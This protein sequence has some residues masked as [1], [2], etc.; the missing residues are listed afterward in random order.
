[1]ARRFFVPTD[2][3]ARLR[4]L[5]IVQAWFHLE[6]SR[7]FGRMLFLYVGLGIVVGL[8]A[9]VFHWAVA[10]AEF[11]FLD[12]MAGYRPATPGGEHLLIKP[13]STPFNPWLLAVMPAL[14]ATL[15]A[16]L[17]RTFAPEAW[18]AGTPAVIQGYHSGGIVRRRVTWVKTI[19]SAL[20]IGT[21]GSAGREGPIAQVGSALG[22]VVA[23]LLKLAP[24]ERRTLVAA[25]AAAGIGALFHAPVAS[26]LFIAEILYRRMELEHEVIVPGLIASIVAYSVYSTVFSWSPLFHINAF[27]FDSPLELGPYIVL[28]IFLALSARVFA[29]MYYAIEHRFDRM[30]GPMWLRPAL[31]GLGVGAIGFVEPDTLGAGYGILQ[32]AIDGQIGL[33]ALLALGLGKML[34]TG[35]TIGSGASGGKFAPSLVI[36][37]AL[38]GFV[39]TATAGVLPGLGMDPGAFVVMGMAGFFAAVSNAPISVIILVSEMTG[40]YHMLV[41]AMWVCIIAWLLTADVSLFAGQRETRLD[42][43]VHLAEAVEGAA[44][45]LKVRDAVDNVEHERLVTV[46]VDTSLAELRVRFARTHHSTFPVVDAAGVLVGVIDDEALR[47]AVQDVGLDHLIVAADLMIVQPTLKL[48]ESLHSALH[49]L[50]STHHDELLIVDDVDPNRLVGTLSRRDVVAFLDERIQERGRADAE[51]RL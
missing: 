14:G 21:G 32:N 31:G 11:L 20:V 5:R 13:S 10:G 25:G 41:P 51:G 39:G 22:S 36:G 29:R 42:S 18:G 33:W 19:A 47:E 50:V 7:D 38:G 35:L 15:S 3:L 6:D 17:V 1:M 30:R 49:K 8:F 48:D 34:T 26:A 46:H 24:A 37:G 9:I 40:N 27:S 28:A 16:I 23:R 44:K 2:R 12:L 45:R 43:Q 4:F